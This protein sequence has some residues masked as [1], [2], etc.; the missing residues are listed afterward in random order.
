MSYQIEI[1]EEVRRALEE[2]PLKPGGWVTPEL[3]AILLEYGSRCQFRDLAKVI[4]K[5][6]GKKIPAKRL[7]YRYKVLMERKEGG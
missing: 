5:M 7:H 6:Y 2:L 4:E 3:D 1:P